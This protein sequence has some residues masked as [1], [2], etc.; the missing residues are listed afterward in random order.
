[1]WPPGR[2]G[3]GRVRLQRRRAGFGPEHRAGGWGWEERQ[4]LRQ[5][6]QERVG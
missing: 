1:M 2:K 3:D 4:S 5:E 6:G